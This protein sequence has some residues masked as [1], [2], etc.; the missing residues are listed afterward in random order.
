MLQI[1]TY[2]RQSVDLARPR[3]LQCFVPDILTS[4]S[5]LRPLISSRWGGGGVRLTSLSHLSRGLPTDF[6]HGIFRPVLF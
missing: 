3:P 2:I 5:L 4:A 1:L 6:F